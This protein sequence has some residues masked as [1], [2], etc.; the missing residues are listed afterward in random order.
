MMSFR[1][2]DLVFPNR[3]YGKLGVFW[4]PE[5]WIFNCVTAGEK[6]HIPPGILPPELLKRSEIIR[7]VVGTCIGNDTM[8][9]R[10]DQLL[11]TLENDHFEGSM[12]LKAG[13][14]YCVEILSGGGVF[15]EFH[16]F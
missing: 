14:R 4:A 13:R 11:L 1:L 15:F 3:V 8:L 5:P 6:F 10:S 16:K 9:R 2:L 7:T 12:H